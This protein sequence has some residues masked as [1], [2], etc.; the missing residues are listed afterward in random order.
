MVRPSRIA[1][2][3]APQTPSAT[4][5]VS[6]A[7]SILSCAVFS[8]AS[9]QA[10]APLSSP[11]TPAADMQGQ[12]QCTHPLAPSLLADSVQ[13]CKHTAGVVNK[14]SHPLCAA[15]LQRSSSS[16]TRSLLSMQLAVQKSSC[17]QVSPSCPTSPTA[18][19]SVPSLP[20]LAC[21]QPYVQRV[22]LQTASFVP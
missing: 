22:W 2:L 1:S 9:T 19:K 15:L 17:E 5:L 10:Q 6:P 18:A 21:L 3:G 12:Q 4:P 7:C 16:S 20:L 14:V 13:E 11:D 8:A